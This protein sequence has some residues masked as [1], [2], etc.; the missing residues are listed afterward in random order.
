MPSHLTNTRWS[1]KT[2][3]HKLKIYPRDRPKHCRT[4]TQKPKGG[5]LDEKIFFF[6][7]RLQSFSKHSQMTAFVTLI[8]K[9]YITWGL[10]TLYVLCTPRARCLS[11]AR[12]VHRHNGCSD[13][14]L[15]TFSE[16]AWQMQ[17][18][19]SVLKKI[20]DN[21][22]KKIFFHLRVPPLVF[23]VFVRQCFGRSRG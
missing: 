7:N 13:P 14:K 20:G 9:R 12:S 23:W 1:V 4:N 15:Y 8:P 21:F 18:F 10:C 6:K 11:R 22:W 5:P 17:S 16:S 2:R 19:G 3:G